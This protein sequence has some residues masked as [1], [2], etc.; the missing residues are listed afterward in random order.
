MDVLAVTDFPDIRIKSA[1]QSAD[2]GS[3]LIIPRE[4]GYLVRL[5]IEL[6]KL[7]RERTGVEP[8]HH[9]RSSDRR[10]A[11]DPASLYA[12][13]EG[14]RVVV[15][16]RDRPT[17]VRPV[18]RRAG[19][20]RRGGFPRVFIAGD[21]C[22]THSPKAGQ[23]MN[24]SM[25]DGFNLGWK[26]A[27]V[28]RGRSA[29][30]NPAHLFGR[31]PGDRQGADRLRPRMG[32]RCSA[33]RR[34]TPRSPIATASIRRSSRTISSSR[35]ASQRERKP[36]TARRSSRAEPTHQHLARASRSA[37]AFIRRR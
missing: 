6:D 22:H 23:G 9:D 10:R 25:Q 35:G 32:D 1:I 8:Q 16:L 12:G 27:S 5:Y 24:V 2:E 18:R 28:L 4:G 21:A 17:P 31:A 30:R 26:L 14:D 11:A 3:L 34:R 36:A 37:C 33:R 19:T 15:G 20:S 29:P 13:G 7:S